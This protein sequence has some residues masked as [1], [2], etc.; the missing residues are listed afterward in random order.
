MSL[1]QH[2]RR[3]EIICTDHADDD[4]RIPEHDLLDERRQRGE[5]DG[6]LQ[7]RQAARK[8]FAQFQRAVALRFE[9]FRLLADFLL[10]LLVLVNLFLIARRDFFRLAVSN[11]PLCSL[12]ASIWT[13]YVFSFR[14]FA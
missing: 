3:E 14:L 7:V 11:C 2:H 12:M 4:A 13:L 9:C 10:F 6:D 8:A 5:Q 1:H